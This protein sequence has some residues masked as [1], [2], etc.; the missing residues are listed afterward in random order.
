MSNLQTSRYEMKYLITESQASAIRRLVTT[1]LTPDTHSL[2][3]GIGYR[4]RSLYLDSRSLTCYN[5]TQRGIKNRY[6]LRI[7]FYDEEPGSPVFLEIKRRITDMIAKSRATVS[8][9][10]AEHLLRGSKPDIGMLLND[11]PREREAL[12][13]FCQLRDQLGAV[14]KAFVD[15]YR[16]AFESKDGNQYR[17]TFDRKVCGSDYQI[18]GGLKM[19]PRSQMTK[20]EGV[21]L[22]MKFIDRPAL[23]M[24]DLSR[25]FNLKAQSVPKYIECVDALQQTAWT[26]PG[27]MANG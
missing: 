23:W 24:I 20:I 16:Q 14:G 6:K 4:V 1:R 18:G 15:Y 10:S 8:R 5:D 19:P 9:Q 21:V 11:S 7:R 22:E 25:R 26:Q 3:S 12:F 13:D 27:A 2:D 17:V